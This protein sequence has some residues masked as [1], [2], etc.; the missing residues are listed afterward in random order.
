MPSRP[1]AI[2]EYRL[3]L[4]IELPVHRPAPFDSFSNQNQ[5]HSAASP[6]AI[7]HLPATTSWRAN[8]QQVSSKRVA[9]IRDLCTTFPH[10]QL[11]GIPSSIWATPFFQLEPSG[12]VTVDRVN[13]V[14]RFVQTKR[15][16]PDD[17]DMAKVIGSK[18][19]R[20]KGNAAWESPVIFQVVYSK[21]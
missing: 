11:A 19:C 15:R 20:R 5:R 14:T 8:D 9:T 10:L 16:A 3:P 2:E 21:L 17:V 1:Q 7:I 12:P 13:P 4:I 6:P 18:R